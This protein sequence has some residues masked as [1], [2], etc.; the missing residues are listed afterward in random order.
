MA[1]QMKRL[2]FLDYSVQDFK[3]L[4]A[5]AEMQEPLLSTY[6]IASQTGEKGMKY[7]LWSNT[8]EVMRQNIK[9]NH[10]QTTEPV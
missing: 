9:L 1:K 8:P 5:L 4:K 6:D 3:A 2:S 10:T 7:L